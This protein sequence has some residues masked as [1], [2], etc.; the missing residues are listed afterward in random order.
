MRTVIDR[1]S[2]GLLAF[3][4]IAL[5]SLLALA[6]RATEP[7]VV[8]KGVLTVPEGILSVASVELVRPDGSRVPVARRPGHRFRVELP[9]K[10]VYHLLFHKPGCRSKAVVVD[11]RNAPA[12]G[13]VKLVFEVVLEPGHG[14][15]MG[16]D[17][18]LAGRIAF[19]PGTG[20]HWVEYR[21]QPYGTHDNEALPGDGEMANE[22]MPPE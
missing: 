5:F 8:V 3:M 22:A 14:V 15:A 11:P 20:R 19:A 17:I 4:L 10:Q 12:D 6:T 9:D 18:T 2:G 13:R 1:M 16:A 21:C 7:P